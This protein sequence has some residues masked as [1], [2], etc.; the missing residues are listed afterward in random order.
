MSNP[1]IAKIKDEVMLA[2]AFGEMFH[3]LVNLRCNTRNWENVYGSE[4][5]DKKKL[6]EGRADN[7]IEELSS[8]KYVVK[9]NKKKGKGEVT[10]LQIK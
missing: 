9:G 2:E 4:A 8:G 5:K 7:L 3:V 1:I 10:K 6:W